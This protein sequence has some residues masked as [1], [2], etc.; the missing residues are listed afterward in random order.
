MRIPRP[1]ATDVAVLRLGGSVV[2]AHPDHLVL[3][4]P[5]NPGF[6]WGNLVLVTD[7]QRADDAMHW[8][9]RFD[10]HFP[11]AEHVSIGLPRA[12][13]A[14][15]YEAVGLAVEPELV[16][17]SGAAPPARPCPQG[18]VVRP[19]AHD[20]EWAQAVA[21]DVALAGPAAA[22]QG[23][24]ERRYC[25]RQW[26]TRQGLAARGEAA[27]LAAFAADGQLASVLGIVLCGPLD[28]ARQ[29]ARYQHV[30]TAPQ[31]RGRGLAS[32]L[33]HAAGAWAAQRGADVWEIHV[34]PG[35]PAHRLYD[36]LGFR[37][38]G[39]LWQAGRAPGS[40]DPTSAR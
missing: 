5:H 29:V 25:E 10:E 15:R 39:V 3:A 35:S 31:H 12:P 13:V 11:D 33:L 24:G 8:V 21:L 36:H 7:P 16:L 9:E 32:H 40:D 14:G 26:R 37:E 27:F 6:H 4:S 23:S 19:L 22:G 30:V 38:L 28:D 34:D 17:V 1:W 2:E 20:G 18:F